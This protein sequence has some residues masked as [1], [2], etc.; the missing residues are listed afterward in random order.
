MASSTARDIMSRAMVKATIIAPGE[1]VPVQKEK[2]VFADL[3]DLLESWQLERLMIYA[4][5]EE[6]FTLTAGK[7]EYTFGT[8]GDF[9]SDRPQ[10]IYGESYIRV[11]TTDY[12]LK[13]KTLEVY[14][15][16]RNKDIQGI[17]YIMAFNPEYPLFKVYL[18]PTPQ[19]D[20]MIYLSSW[21]QLTEFADLT[22]PVDLPPG[23]R[24]AIVLNLALELLPSF[25]KVAVPELAGL[26]LSAK[27]MIKRSNANPI[28]SVR[29]P[30]LAAMAGRGSSGT[31][32]NTGPWR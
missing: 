14:R 25:G 27:R 26:A 1:A 4:K 9:D 8:G 20:S 17:P 19:D 5:V 15:R 13:N 10:R 12:R 3:N 29:N 7:S 32:I 24:R 11:G 16:L 31:T 23:Y 18:Y 21:K 6:S 22:T 2:Q 28:N 30:G